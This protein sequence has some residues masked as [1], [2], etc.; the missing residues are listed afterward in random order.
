MNPRIGSIHY[1]AVRIRRVIGLVAAATVA[2]AAALS[3]GQARSETRIGAHLG[4]YHF[5]GDF[6]NFNPGVY[7]YHNGWTAGTYYN[8]ERRQSVYAGYTAEWQLSEQWSAAVT[9]GA[10]TGYQR[11]AVLPMAVPSLRWSIPG[12]LGTAV[13][14]SFVPPVGK[15]SSAVVHASIEW[16]FK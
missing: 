2:C 7:V 9:V 10:I 6:N 11:A 8:S 16:R 3:C 12:A 5:S 13:R 15:G 14:V 1:D 4:S